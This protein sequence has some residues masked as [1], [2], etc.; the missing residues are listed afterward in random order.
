MSPSNG[1]VIISFFLF[2]Q[3]IIHILKLLHWGKYLH[4]P[5]Q[6]WYLMQERK[7]STA[8]LSNPSQTS[9]FY[10]GTEKSNQVNQNNLSCILLAEM[11][12]Y[13]PELKSSHATA[14]LQYET[15]T[16]PNRRLFVRIWYKFEDDWWCL[17]SLTKS[18]ILWE[19]VL[20]TRTQTIYLVN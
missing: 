3:S 19:S 1:R 20:V 2:F 4:I 17:M 8:K 5:R 14:W 11:A 13:S 15:R 9:Y 16:E 12:P 7:T 6:K 10:C 18:G